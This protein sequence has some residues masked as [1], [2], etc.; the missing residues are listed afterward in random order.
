MPPLGL[1]PSRP[2]GGRCTVTAFLRLMSF[3]PADVGT[4]ADQLVREV[5][6]PRLRAQPHARHVYAGRAGPDDNGERVVASI[7]DIDEELGDGP[8]ALAELYDFERSDHI[9]Q[10]KLEVFPLVLLLPFDLAGEASILRVFRGQAQ[11]GELGIYIDEA[12]DG[13][14][15]DVAARHGPAALFLGI[16]EPDGFI[17]VSVWTGWENIEA[18]TGGNLRQ[19]MATRH[20]ERLVSGVAT[21]YE[22][23]PKT[24]P[25]DSPG[26]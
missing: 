23:V 8:R 7:W 1:H 10:V 22:I 6:V 14:Y 4:V 9:V 20:A 18:A 19:P 25:G 15:A 2:V 26:D 13:T 5:I 24:M 11:P 12:R 16:A 17:T 21:H 3:F